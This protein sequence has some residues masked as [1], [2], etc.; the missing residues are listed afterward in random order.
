MTD[1][2]GT[3]TDRGKPPAAELVE[4]VDA[5]G[6]V[7]DI[8][9]RA[10]IRARNLWHRCTYIAVT[11]SAGELVVHQRA[12]WKDVYPSYWDLCFGGIAGVGEDWETAARRELAEEAGIVGVELTDL[13]PVRYE[14]AEGDAADGRIV[15]RAYKV[16]HD[17]P[18]TCPDGEVV[19]IDRIPI[20]DLD[21]WLHE[22]PVCPDSAE[23]VAALVH[24]RWLPSDG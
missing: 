2:E 11:T 1:P 4:V 9:T 13:G 24:A 20:A 7:L 23:L 22:R 5:E 19:A 6:E 21:A 14:R 15:G 17:G 12:S 16:I 3:A 10:E 8:V 18:L